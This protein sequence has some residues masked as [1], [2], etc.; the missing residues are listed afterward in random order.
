MIFFYLVCSCVSG[1]AQVPTTWKKKAFFGFRETKRLCQKHHFLRTKNFIR[2]VWI[3]TCH[4]T[5]G[6]PWGIIDWMVMERGVGYTVDL[7]VVCCCICSVCRDKLFTRGWGLTKRKRI[8]V[9]RDSLSS[10]WLV[11]RIIEH[12][13]CTDASFRVLMLMLWFFIFSLRQAFQS[14][15]SWLEN[16]GLGTSGTYYGWWIY[17]WSIWWLLMV[18]ILVGC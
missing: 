8:T 2:G 4:F 11:G 12:Q 7:L 17:G 14:E 18:L 16:L 5:T 1:L 15:R 13:K 10:V 6:E 9:I 3:W